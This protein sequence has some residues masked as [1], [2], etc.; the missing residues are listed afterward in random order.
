MRWD[1]INVE[2]AFMYEYVRLNS[3]LIVIQECKKE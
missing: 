2:G 1:V 3:M